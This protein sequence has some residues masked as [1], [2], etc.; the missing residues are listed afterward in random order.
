[1]RV[2]RGDLRDVYVDDGRA[3]VMVGEQVLVLSELATAILASVPEDGGTTL[4]EVAAAVEA[5][6][7]PPAPPGTALDLTRDQLHALAAHRVLTVEEESG[8]PV[9]SDGVTSPA[10]VRALRKALRH[11]LS[12]TAGAWRTPHT[13][14]GADL[15]AAARQH[16]V[17]SFLHVHRERLHLPAGPAAELHAEA[18]RRQAA[19]AVLSDDLATALD[20][21]DRHGVRALAV[22]GITLAAQAHGDVAARGAGDLDLLVRPDDA[23]RAQAALVQ[24]GWEHDP[25]Y[26]VP[27]PSWAWRHLLRTGHELSLTSSRSTVDLH[28]HLA[29]S[30]STYPAFDALWGR[31]SVVAVGGRDVPTLSPYDALA[32]S[33]GH[34]AKDGWR[35]LRSLVDVHR[36]ASEPATWLAADRP[37]RRDQLVSVGL[38]AR[39]FGVPEGAPPVVRAAMTLADTVWD[40]VVAR[41][42][43]TDSRHV[44]GAVPGR[45]L[46]TSLRTLGLTSAA[47]GDVARQLGFSLM[48]PWIT[49]ADSS[50]HAY[51]AAPRALWRRGLDASHRVRRTARTR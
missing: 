35:W 42:S 8:G 38:A 10:A 33:A 2:R 1:M 16:H 48:P 46:L 25:A 28:W 4:P 9:S 51:V 39:M 12:E 6:F 11:V 36:L 18:A 41:Q 19:V 30:H 45:G 50:P 31:R 14:S 49:T 3:A 15:L 13:V 37:L 47:P 7:G 23:A 34:A 32:H 24:A 17:V 43:G 22:K 5:E 21:L 44:T 20:A 26:P 27:G 29:P 40:D